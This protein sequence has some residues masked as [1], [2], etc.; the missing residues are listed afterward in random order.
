M[1]RNVSKD[2][3]PGDLD[4][5][6]EVAEGEIIVP[7]DPDDITDVGYV[8]GTENIMQRIYITSY[9]CIIC[10]FGESRSRPN[11]SD[12]QVAWRRG[13]CVGCDLQVLRQFINNC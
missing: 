9:I 3:E 11:F 6:E 2:S 8:E 10:L 1:L 4:A 5:E 7:A 13:R 12:G